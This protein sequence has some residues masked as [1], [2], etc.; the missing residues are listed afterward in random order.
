MTPQ[1]TSAHSIQRTVGL[2]L[3]PPQTRRFRGGEAP[4]LGQPKV[5]FGRPARP[6]RPPTQSP[7]FQTQSGANK[8]GHH[9]DK[10]Y[11]ARTV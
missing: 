9:L 11:S 10:Y 1:S 7:S 3:R 2:R 5:F 8:A 4:D 6:C